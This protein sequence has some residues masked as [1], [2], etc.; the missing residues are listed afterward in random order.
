MFTFKELGMEM[1]QARFIINDGG[2]T[3]FRIQEKDSKELVEGSYSI[4]F[5]TITL[6]DGSRRPGMTL[7]VYHLGV[8]VS[9]YTGQASVQAAVSLILN[10]W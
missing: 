6:G 1:E 5:S 9:T 7:T 10:G 4:E 8:N 2:F 3:R